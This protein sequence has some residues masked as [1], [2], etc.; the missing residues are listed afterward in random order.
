MPSLRQLEYLVELARQ[1]HFRR[2]AE[3]L[4]VSQPT[5]STQL[6][7]L[8]T[9]LGLELVER[10]RSSVVI[11]P[12]GQKI[13]EIARRMLRDRQEILDL[14]KAGRGPLSGVMR[15]GL[16]SSI[17][18]NLLPLM[19]PDLHRRHP[20]LALHVREDVPRNLVESLASGL[21]DMLLVP[22]PFDGPDLVTRAIFR[23]PLHVAMAEDHPLARK[24]P[25]TREDLMHQRV[26]TLER[27][28]QL[29]EQVNAICAEFGAELA[30]DFEGTSLDTVS[31]MVAMGTG[32]TFLPGLYVDRALR[33]GDGIVT[34][35]LAGRALNRTVGAVWRAT[36]ARTDDYELM[37]RFIRQAVARHF[38]R[39]VL[40]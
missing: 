28:H 7:A 19:L 21:H 18:P 1:R 3:A 14:A 37:I 15:L 33:A 8:E 25:L 24:Q 39:Y 35:E 4:G 22:L 11:T 20:D 27:G 31:Q 34:R 16:P 13:V 6:R 30:F 9:R 38:P 40:L 2:A 32:I 5:L 23:E 29:Q 36:S 10:S 17:G 12:A 26:L